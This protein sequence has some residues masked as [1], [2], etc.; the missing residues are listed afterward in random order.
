M[1]HTRHASLVLRSG[2]D[3][4]PG[5]GRKRQ[6][7]RLLRGD[8]GKR[9]AAALKNVQG[10]NRKVYTDSIRRRGAEKMP[11]KGARIARKA[12]MVPGWPNLLI[13]AGKS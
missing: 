2:L 11:R 12:V 5:N 7:E 9:Y 13:S 10:L 4:A 1:A 6:R 3:A 8:F